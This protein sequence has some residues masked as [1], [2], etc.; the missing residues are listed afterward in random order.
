MF[1]FRESS[2]VE[3]KLMA[4]GRN[5]HCLV[6]FNKPNGVLCQFSDTQR[7]PT[8]ANYINI[9][10]FYPAG[11]L[12]FNTEGLVLLTNNGMMQARICEPRFGLQ[13]TYLAQ[14]EGSPSRTT[15]SKLNSTLEL[16]DG[17][18]KVISAKIVE[19][20]SVWTRIPP[21]RIRRLIPTSWLQIVIDEGRNR[22][23][24]RMTASVGLPTLRLIRTRVGPWHLWDIPT[25]TFKVIY[26]N[27]PSF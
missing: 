8:L 20:P 10:N 18:S 24:R 21:V 15:I 25:G 23:V 12:D 7:R 13:K 2:A 22:Q 19:P 11:R 14:V 16:N 9:P 4:T 3:Q 17:P 6:L 27:L 26:T 1:S 5:R